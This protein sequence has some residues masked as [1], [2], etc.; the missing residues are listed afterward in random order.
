MSNYTLK[1]N[2]VSEVSGESDPWLEGRRGSWPIR[3]RPG[4]DVRLSATVVMRCLRRWSPPPR[5]QC[6]RPAAASDVSRSVTRTSL[7]LTRVSQGSPDSRGT[8]ARPTSPTAG[9]PRSRWNLPKP[10]T[11]GQ[12]W[13]YSN[14]TVYYGI[15]ECSECISHSRQWCS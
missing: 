8:P 10:C 9:E 15:H 14:N 12:Q 13:C 5:R 4:R 7:G 3:E 6:C 2:V 11:H 1:G